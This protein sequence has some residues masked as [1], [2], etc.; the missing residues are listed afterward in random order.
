MFKVSD[1]SEARGNSV[2]AREILDKASNDIQMGLAK[3]PELQARL[4]YTMGNVYLGLGLDSC[5]QSLLERAL[6]IQRRFLGPKH[7]E[8]LQTAT[9]LANALRYSGRYPE[10][11]KMERQTIELQR[12][13][14]GPQH[15]DTLNSVGDLAAALFSE[16]RYPE[17][18][19]LQR[20]ALDKD[21][22]RAIDAG[23]TDTGHMASEDQLKSLRGTE[24]FKALLAE[25]R[26]RAST[27]QETN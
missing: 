17:A 14:L 24:R 19:K 20:D 11:E 8:T 12:H 18:E 16:D 26:K 9:S 4:M 23:Y 10:P 27:T 2:T 7:P 1:P 22:G 25:T 6:D 21:L 15:P 3:H 13:F 5:A